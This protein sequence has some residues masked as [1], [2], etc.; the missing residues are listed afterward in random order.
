MKMTIAVAGALLALV[1]GALAYM[2]VFGDVKVGE[3]E[4]GPYPFVYIQDETTDFGRIGELTEALGERLEA[5]G[6]TQRKPAQIYYSVG[7][8]IQNQIGFVVD[9]AVSLEVLGADTFF[10]P[11]PRQRCTVARFPYRNSL[12][13]M[14]GRFRVDPAFM[15]YRKA[16]GYEETS[17]I[18]I[19]EGREILY[20]Q[21]IGPA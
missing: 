8:G 6:Y 10:R 4:V 15:A 9:R 20:L 17:T 13:F 5:A 12:S 18:V 19:R 2:G 14:V 1:A 3:Q 11:L 16:K 21:P 7:R